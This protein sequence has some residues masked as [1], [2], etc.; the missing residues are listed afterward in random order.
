MEVPKKENKK[1]TQIPI[2]A[3]KKEETMDLFSEELY[4]NHENNR[5]ETPDLNP[6]PEYAQYEKDL[7]V[8]LHRVNMR[9]T[10]GENKF[11][12]SLIEQ[13]DK[14]DKNIQSDNK[15]KLENG[16]IPF[17][18]NIDENVVKNINDKTPLI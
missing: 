2:G 4:K 6:K 13:I 18:E 17:N 10:I 8:N 5:R 9:R 15:R 14:H 1:E 16:R 12:N 3:Q 7:M 11:I